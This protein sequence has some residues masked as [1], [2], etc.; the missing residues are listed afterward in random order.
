MPSAK[1]RAPTRGRRSRMRYRRPD[2]CR[3]AIATAPRSL[4]RRYRQDPWPLQCHRWAS[5][6]VARQTGEPHDRHGN[7]V[8]CEA[9]DEQSGLGEMLCVRRQRHLPQTRT[10]RINERCRAV[11]QADHGVGAGDAQP[12]HGLDSRSSPARRSRQ[13]HLGGR[14]TADRDSPPQLVLRRHRV[15]TRDVAHRHPPRD[16]PPPA[17]HAGLRFIAA[18]VKK[19]GDDQ[20]GQLAALI[21][22]YA[23]VSIFPLLL[24]FVTILGFVLAGASRDQEKIVHGTLGQFPILSDS[25]EA[26][27]AE[28]Q[29]RRAGDRHRRHAARRHGHYERRAEHVQQHLG[30]APQEPAQLPHLAPAQSRDARDPR[31]ADDRLDGRRGLRRRELSRRASPSSQA[32]SS[33]SPSTSRSS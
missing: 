24:V 9:A 27:C 31:H 23:F 13:L 3:D 20:A 14:M 4:L 17:A 7:L 29:R 1:R 33:P 5:K 21:A 22:Y 28:R 25:L 32:C 30:R 12:R 6:V 26:A 15:D 19:F 10:R 18:V 2:P 8:R 16:R 11:G